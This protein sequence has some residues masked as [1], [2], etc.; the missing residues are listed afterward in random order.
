LIALEQEKKRKEKEKKNII[1]TLT[2]I[3]PTLVKP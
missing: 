3:D 1:K 2:W